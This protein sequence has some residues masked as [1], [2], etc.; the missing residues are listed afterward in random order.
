MSQAGRAKSGVPEVQGEALWGT[1]R[2]K[3]NQLLG[4]VCE[5]RRCRGHEAFRGSRADSSWDLARGV[6]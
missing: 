4:R 1:T 2:V 5:V 3:L 6:Q